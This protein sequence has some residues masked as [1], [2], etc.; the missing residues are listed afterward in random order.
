MSLQRHSSAREECRQ[1]PP[2]GARARD[3]APP[4][5]RAEDVPANELAQRPA[6]GAS[7]GPQPPDQEPALKVDVDAGIRV[8]GGLAFSR[9]QLLAA[10]GA[11]GVAVGWILARLL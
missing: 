8:Q 7:P 3:G 11:L 10:L 9:R 2:I 6:T 4:P 5:V 1:K